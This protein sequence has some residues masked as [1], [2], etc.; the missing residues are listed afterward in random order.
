MAQ[1]TIPF[2]PGQVVGIIGFSHAGQI[3]EIHIDQYGE[4]YDL[5]EPWDDGGAIG[6][7]DRNEIYSLED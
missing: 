5:W 4:S 6:W 7:F 2:S 3:M 1:F